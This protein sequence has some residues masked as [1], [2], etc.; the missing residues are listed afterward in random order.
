MP[1]TVNYLVLADK[2][3]SLQLFFFLFG[4][5]FVGNESKFF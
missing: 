2:F 1:I 3:E 4:Q 5:S